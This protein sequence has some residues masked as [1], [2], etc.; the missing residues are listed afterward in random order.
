[1]KKKLKELGYG[2]E[3]MLRL[4]RMFFVYLRMC[5]GQEKNAQSKKT[6]M[7]INGIRNICADS[8]L[9]NVIKQYPTNELGIKQRVFL[10]LVLHKHAALLYALSCA[11]VV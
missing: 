1:M 7:K 2:K 3:T 9:N 8:I 4:D 11:R 5:I 6:V 10:N